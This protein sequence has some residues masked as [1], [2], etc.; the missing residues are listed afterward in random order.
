M[1]RIA[2]CLGIALLLGG[3]DVQRGTVKV[4]LLV[5]Q[6]NMQ[7][8]GAVRHLDILIDD[9]ETRKVFEHLKKDNEQVVRDDVWITYKRGKDKPAKGG[10]TVG[11]GSSGKGDQIGPELGFGHVVGDHL[12]EPV[13]LIKCAW[14]GKSLKKDFLPPSAGGPGP[15]YTQMVKEVR[16]ALDN[17]EKHFPELKGKGHEI[18]GVVWFQG[19]NDHVGSGNPEYTEQLAGFVRDVRKEFKVPDLPFIIGEL[20]QAGPDPK[21]AKVI[22][23]RKQQAAVARIKEFKGRVKF[24]KTGEFIN[25][26]AQELFNVWSKCRGKAAK[27]KRDGD[28]EAAKTA[29]DEW[30]AVKEEYEKIASD[31]GYH[32]FGSFKTFY[33]MGNAFGRAMVELLKKE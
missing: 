26:R 27:A 8:K 13:L 28:E 30:N 19:W 16:E 31:R 33:L 23:F 3:A 24:V 12:D 6:S 25:P 15:F 11:Y 20:G 4:F 5:G 10:L 17:L 32:Y 14:G 29:W 2:L 7:G 22:K 18:A 9:P 1:K 21:N